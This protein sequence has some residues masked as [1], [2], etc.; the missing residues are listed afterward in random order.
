MTRNWVSMY[1]L[2]LYHC[3]LLVANAAGTGSPLEVFLCFPTFCQS[4]LAVED[5]LLHGSMMGDL[6]FV[7][8]FDKDSPSF[9]C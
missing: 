1:V 8:S 6:A 5:Q 4:G 3:R 9:C 7:N 2:D